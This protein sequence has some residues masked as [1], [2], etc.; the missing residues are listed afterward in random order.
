MP[1]NLKFPVGGMHTPYPEWEICF[2]QSCISNPCHHAIFDADGKGFTVPRVVVGT[3]CTSDNAYIC[4][5]CILEA[6]RNLPSNQ[7]PE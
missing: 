5:D 1:E 3:A 2:N 6:A 7:P 4:L